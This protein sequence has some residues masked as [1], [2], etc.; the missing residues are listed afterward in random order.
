MNNRKTSDSWIFVRYKLCIADLPVLGF[1]LTK[2]KK[3]SPAPCVILAHFQSPYSLLLAQ[4]SRQTPVLFEF[5]QQCFNTQSSSI[6]SLS[7]PHLGR[8]QPQEIWE[9]AARPAELI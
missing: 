6:N 7:S 8:K 1:L 5:A 9:C 3:K 4:M 2:K